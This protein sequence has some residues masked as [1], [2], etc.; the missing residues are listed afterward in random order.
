M[1][2]VAVD[3]ARRALACVLITIAAGG[4]AALAAGSLAPKTLEQLPTPSS[5]RDAPRA[6]TARHSTAQSAGIRAL[7]LCTG[8]FA[9]P[10]PRS[11][12][13]T[14]A[15]TSANPIAPPETPTQVDEEGKS[16]SVYYTED[17]P[18]RIAVARPILGCTLLPVG[19]LKAL[20]AGLPQ[21]KATAPNFDDQPWPMGDR[22]ATASLPAKQRAAVESV[23]D[24]A[25][26]DDKGVY[27][28]I[29]WGVVVIRGG[30]I[31]AERY[32]YGFDAHRQARTNSMCK[33]ISGTLAGIGIHKGLL[34]LHRKTILREWR[35]HGDPRGE[36]TINDLMQMSSGLYTESAGD[37]QSD[38][39]G[40]GAAV[41]EAAALNVVEYKPGSH[42]VYAGADSLLIVRAL[43]QAINDDE[44][45]LTF[46][47]R[48]LLWKTGMTRTLIETDWKNDFVTSGQC[49]STARD[50]GRFGMLYLADGVWQGE[51]ILPKGW[52]TYVSTPA[53]AQTAR[54]ASPR[55]GGQFWIY[56]GMAGLPELAYSPNGSRG[57]Y[58]MI[59]PSRDLVV[60]RRGFDGREGFDIAKFSADVMSAVA[61]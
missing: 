10:A 25:F 14:I 9:T 40:S 34:D 39:Y 54:E 58:A 61:E 16:V 45:F 6:G 1:P 27:R 21:P 13:D 11:F 2:Y 3:R 49:W 12:T 7:H 20:S 56:G 26:K 32:Q 5:R 36:I 28:G 59:I 41:S 37:R 42:F 22:N 53:P 8:Y 48:E 4:D 15:K 60:V 19:A 29:T 46:P 47:H 43:R 44:A 18:P 52:S 38:I 50:F 30:K 51:R 23:I 33:S 24:E 55:Y 17:L 57:Q 31:I 35:A